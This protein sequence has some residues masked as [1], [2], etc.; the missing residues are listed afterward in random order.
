MTI[1]CMCAFHGNI[2]YW[3]QYSSKICIIH[4]GSILEWTCN[5]SMFSFYVTIAEQRAYVGTKTI[6]TCIWD[7]KEVYQS[8]CDLKHNIP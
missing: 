5:H 4:L 3:D 1:Q 2:K 6:A 8:P 7:V